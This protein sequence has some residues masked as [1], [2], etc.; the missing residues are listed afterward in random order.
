VTSPA[1]RDRRPAS[2][3]RPDTRA[4]HTTPD[5]SDGEEPRSHGVPDVGAI[6]KRLRVQNGLTLQ[7]VAAASGLSTSFLSAVERGES[8]IAVGRLARIAEFFNHDVGSL[9]G[10]SSRRSRP[11]F[12]PREDKVAIARGAGVDYL[13]IRVA[14]LGVELFPVRFA[15]HSGFDK[16]IAHEGIDAVY[17]V[18]GEVILKLDG[19]DHTIAQG[20]CAV[21]SAAYEHT[22]RNDRDAPAFIVA[23]GDAGVY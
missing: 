21:F 12:V 9:L 14:A 23:V 18:E 11:R 13:A 15:P 8:D 17:A 2:K 4:G 19:D 10:F 20:E 6:I 5:S 7:D 3:S 22:L 16:A 1:P